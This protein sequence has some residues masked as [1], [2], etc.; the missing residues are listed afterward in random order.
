[1]EFS[2]VALVTGS[3]RER[4][5]NQ[6]VRGLAE[7]GY[8]VAVHYHQSAESA[9]AL[10]E[11]LE[12]SGRDAMEVK[13]DISSSVEVGNM[14]QQVLDRFGRLDVLVNTASIWEQKP[15]EN[16]T[17]EDLEKHFNVDLKGTFLC[18][19]IAGLQMCRQES[20]GAIVMFSDWAISRP[21]PD[22]AAYFSVKGAIPTMMRCFARELGQRNPRVRV[23]CIQPGPV[24]LPESADAQE[25]AA[26]EA[27]TLV[28]QVDRPDS[29]VQAVRY[30]IGDDFITGVCLPVDGGRSVFAAGEDR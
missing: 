3:G 30:L 25:R 14:V 21:Y 5:G 12:L 18:S 27:S 16:V 6:I 9:R 15:L 29:I 8:R 1:M 13:A 24:L 28:R 4:L 10:V 19:Q 22:H 2:P 11:D 20:G 17:A 7:D 23:N 26:L